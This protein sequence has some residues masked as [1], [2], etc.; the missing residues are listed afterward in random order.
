MTVC[1]PGATIESLP[2]RQD[3]AH[4]SVGLERVP[5]KDE[6]RGP[7]PCV[8]RWGLKTGVNRRF[9]L[10]VVLA[11]ATGVLPWLRLA[12]IDRDRGESIDALWYDPSG[13]DGMPSKAWSG[14]TRGTDLGCFLHVHTP[15][16]HRK[17]L[18]RTL[19]PPSLGPDAPAPC[20]RRVFCFF[21]CVACG[22]DATAGRRQSRGLT[23]ATVPRAAAPVPSPFPAA[24]RVL[25]SGQGRSDSPRRLR[26][27]FPH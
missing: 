4:S 22:F 20:R 9:Q 17:P 16:L 13:Q 14:D 27:P 15:D 10:A 12:G 11:I 23:P 8:P 19:G 25:R 2:S 21:N 7:N 18:R 24:R 6:V 26:P 1:R 5:D 3:R